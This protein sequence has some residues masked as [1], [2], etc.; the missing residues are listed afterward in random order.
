[1]NAKQKIVHGRGPSNINLGVFVRSFDVCRASWPFPSINYVTLKYL[2]YIL[3]KNC[4]SIDRMLTGFDRSTRLRCSWSGF[5]RVSRLCY[6]LVL[7][8]MSLSELL[9]LYDIAGER[10]SEEFYWSTLSE[11][12]P[13]T[14]QNDDTN[15]RLKLVDKNLSFQEVFTDVYNGDLDVLVKCRVGFKK[16]GDAEP[17]DCLKV[18]V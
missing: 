4:A 3:I 2:I 11:T 8:S 12:D 16:P 1:M 7:T 14:K 18:T 10:L 15:L 5:L 9:F 13:P 6:N 17:K